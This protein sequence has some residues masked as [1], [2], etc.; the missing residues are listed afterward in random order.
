MRPKHDIKFNL[1]IKIQ[2]MYI[3]T[4]ESM[5]ESGAPTVRYSN[6]TYLYIMVGNDYSCA[7]KSYI[8]LFHRGQMKR[9]VSHI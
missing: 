9:Y 3:L 5:Q 7:Y 6:S 8:V 2:A 1:E 4:I